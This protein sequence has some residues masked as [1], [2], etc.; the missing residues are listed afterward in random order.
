MWLVVGQAGVIMTMGKRH[1]QRRM[2]GSDRGHKRDR[3]GEKG[4]GGGGGGE[5]HSQGGREDRKRLW[6]RG[7]VRKGHVTK[8]S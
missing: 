3:M 2:R 1:S 8:V 6:E 4:G 7:A 5:N